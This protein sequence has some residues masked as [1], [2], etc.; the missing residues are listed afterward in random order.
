MA[1]CM[2]KQKPIGIVGVISLWSQILL[3]KTSVV[4]KNVEFCT[5]V[6]IIFAS[7]HPMACVSHNLNICWV[8]CYFISGR[9]EKYCDEYV[10]LSVC[11]SVCLSVCCLSAQITRKPPGRTSPIFC[12]CC[13]WPYLGPPMRHCDTLCTSGFG[14]NV[15][16]SHNGPIMALMAIKHEKHNCQDY[17]Q[18]LV[19]DKTSKYV[20]LLWV[21]LVHQ[22]RSLPSTIDLF[23]LQLGWLFSLLRV[24]L[25]L[26]ESTIVI[27]P[28]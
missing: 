12:A 7:V 26:N 3:R 4:R 22:W 2:H 13:L 21:V 6:T 5:L 20:Y 10:F 14:Y 27:R 25:G 16:F 24:K 19:S 15:K 11:V 28:I 9:D 8:S 17:N 23:A 18:I 1:T